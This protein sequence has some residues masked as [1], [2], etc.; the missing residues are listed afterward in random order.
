[1]NYVKHE[2]GSY[3]LHLIKTDKFKTVTVK[4][5]FRRPAKKEE[6]TMRNVLANLLLRSSRTYNSERL[7]AIA[8]EELYGISY[9]GSAIL[10]GSYNMLCFDFS[11]LNEKYTEEGMNEKSFAFLFDMLFNPHV[12]NKKF[13]SENLRY[14]KK[15]VTS[16]IESVREDSKRFGLHRLFDTMASDFPLSYHVDGY[17]EDMEKIT[18]ESLYSY[19]QDVIQKDLVD[20]FVIGSVADYKVKRYVEKGFAVHTFKKTGRSHYIKN[21][22]VRMRAQSIKENSSFHQSQLFVG[23][24]IVKPSFYELNYVSYIYNMILG[25]GADAKLFRTL[26]EE[27]HLCYAISSTRYLL[28]SVLVIHAGI[29]AEQYKKAVSLIRREIKNMASGK[30]TEEDMTKAKI[31]Y[32]S[33]LKEMEDNPN[34]ILNM[35]VSKEFLGLDL[36]C[37]RIEKIGKVSKK[38][39]M[40]FAKKIKWNTTYLLKEDASHE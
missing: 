3:R 9:S 18:E 1:M 11:F 28:N 33:G 30:F 27:N 38:Q 24:N 8:D 21:N 34:S 26:R 2:M 37:D 14:S 10:S 39:V 36:P 17:L 23:L 29:Q 25:G 7:L 19:Y 15:L 16:N 13:D 20:I 35:Y 6:I 5:F 12:Q 22:K 4:I 31:I 40:Q 32:V